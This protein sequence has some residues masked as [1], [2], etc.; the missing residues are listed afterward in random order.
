MWRA[1]HKRNFD[2]ERRVMIVITRRR[3]QGRL[4]VKQQET[5]PE[6]SMKP[7]HKRMALGLVALC[8]VGVA[9][10]LAVAAL[11]GNIAYFFS[12]SQVQAGAVA[13]GEVF[14]VGGMV[15]EG[16]L[17]K[18]PDS[19]RS[20]F[21]MTDYGADVAV[22]YTGILPDLFKEGQGAVARGRLGEDGVFYAE[23]VL[24]KHDESYMPP[25][26]TQALRAAGGEAR[27][28]SG[29]GEPLPPSMGAYQ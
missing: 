5:N 10:A 13:A 24:A 9:A 23:Q 17:Q 1:G 8:A 7:R 26:V 2:R 19:L 11:R 20:G 22:V 14:R 29:G 16:S 12:P 3:V 25:E 4:S 18:S 27:A 15:R 21:V 28:Q 6:Q